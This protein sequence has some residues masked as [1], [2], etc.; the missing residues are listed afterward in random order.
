MSL[1]YSIVIGCLTLFIGA[2]TP[3]SNADS[4]ADNKEKEVLNAITDNKNIVASKDD[5]IS[6]MSLSTGEDDSELEA[7]SP[8]IA[9]TPLP[10]T[11]SPSPTPA[12]VYEL[13]ND[14]NQ[15]INSF[16]NDYYVAVNGCDINQ[17]S[18]LVTDS[19]DMKPI[20]VM[21]K[22]TLFID[23]IRNINCYYMKSYEDGAYIVYVTYDIKYINIKNTYPKLEKFYLITDDDGELKSF[24]SIMDEDLKNYYDESDQD[25]KV[26]EIIEMIASSQ[27]EVLDKD[28]DLK[29]YLEALYN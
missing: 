21:E 15:K 19:N 13:K 18:R 7:T 1:I 3:I 4:I 16:F 2:L 27:K 11:P 6:S 17:L 5:G 29:A 12:P 23:D 14:G 24:T 9:P 26:A 10:T 28:S 8:T 22:E 25:E 20:K